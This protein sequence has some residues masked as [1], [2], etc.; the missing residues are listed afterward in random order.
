MYKFYLF[1]NLC[2]IDWQLSQKI[3]SLGMP[4]GVQFGGELAAMAIISL[5]M[6]YFGV[7]ALVATQVVAQYSMLIIMVMLALSQALSVLLS[8]AMG[9][10]DVALVKNYLIAA[11]ILL[12]LFFIGVIIIFLRYPQ[13]LIYLYMGAT[14]ETEVMRLTIYFF[15][16]AAFAL[17]F[18]G[19]R[20]L[21][22]GAL[23]GL[24]YSLL[25]MKVGLMCLWLIA[26]PL[27]YLTAFVFAQGAIGL[28]IGFAVGFI[29]AAGLLSK[30]LHK[31][32]TKIGVLHASNTYQFN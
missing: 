7:A 6:G 15:A 24:Q 5:W 30:H 25:P 9:R 16:I 17:L 28:R 14:I 22:A 10:H 27:S 19:I 12:G 21:L 2:R 13:Q 3:F 4:I 29:L 1:N 31:I 18:D 23:R 32:L 20:H 8:E 26:L 11:F